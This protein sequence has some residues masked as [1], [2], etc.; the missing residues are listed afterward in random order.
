[1]EVAVDLIFEAD[2]LPLE[3]LLQVLLLVLCHLAPLHYAVDL[4]LDIAVRLL[5]DVCL[6][7]KHVYIVVE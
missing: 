4:V 3:L 1:M 7:I 2:A 5:K 6:R